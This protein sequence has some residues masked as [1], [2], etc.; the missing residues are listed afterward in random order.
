MRTSADFLG[1]NMR[2]C[3]IAKC[4]QMSCDLQA[5]RLENVV[6]C[7]VP[8]YVFTLFRFS[9]VEVSVIMGMQCAI[10]GKKPCRGIQVRPPRQGQIPRRRRPQGH[11]HDATHASSRT[12]SASRS[13]STARCRPSASA[14]RRSAAAWSSGRSSA[15][16][17]RCRTCSSQPAVQGADRT[18]MSLSADEVRWVA[19][20]ARLELTEAELETMTRQLSAIVD[21][22]DQLQASEHRR[23]RAAGPSA[24][25]PQRLPRRRAGPVAA[26]DEALANAPHARAISIGVPP[27]FG[28]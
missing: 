19:H 3:S 10:T 2:R 13:R 17:S 15:S 24:R 4:V 18:S 7:S 6:D 5:C 21:Y 16:R 28:D 11:R 27:V 26:V 14:S 1:V 22:V 23:R 8:L 12:C 9:A 20:L 25:S